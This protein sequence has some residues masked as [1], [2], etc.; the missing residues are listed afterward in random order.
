MRCSPRCWVV[1]AKGSTVVHVVSLLSFSLLLWVCDL[2]ALIESTRKISENITWN[3]FPIEEDIIWTVCWGRAFIVRTFKRTIAC[4][5]QRI[6]YHYYNDFCRD[7][8]ECC[9]CVVIEQ[10]EFAPKADRTSWSSA[11]ASVKP[12]QSSETRALDCTHVNSIQY[13]SER[14]E[15]ANV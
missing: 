1:L 10:C 9:Y 7:S 6:N 5:C 3:L 12:G 11:P 4:R 2:I 8:S 13:D 15:R 14:I